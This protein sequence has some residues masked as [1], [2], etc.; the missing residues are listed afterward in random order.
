MKRYVDSGFSAEIP[1]NAAEAYQTLQIHNRSVDDDLILTAYQYIVQENPMNV[2]LYNKALTAI[3]EE[4]DSPAL[5]NLVQNT[6]TQGVQGS[7]DEP[8]GL[9]NIGNTCYL[10]SLLQFLFTI[11]PFRSV[12]LD[13]ENFKMDPIVENMARKKV[14]Q[15]QV[16]LKEVQTSQKCKLYVQTRI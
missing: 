14:G 1:L 7:T 8:V 9:E 10:N 13:F 3:A 4:R 11:T 12:V 16:T 6:T 15:R 5:R 2:D